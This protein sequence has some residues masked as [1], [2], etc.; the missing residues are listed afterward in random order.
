MRRA[1]AVSVFV[2]VLIASTHAVLAKE[3]PEEAKLRALDQKWSD[4]FVKKD[5]NAV[6]SY[7]ADDAVLM[8]P[9]PALMVRGK[10]AIRKAFAD[11]FA[12]E[13]AIAFAVHDPTYRVVGTLG[14]G[15]ATFDISSKNK[16]T[17][18]T[19]SMKGRASTVFEKRGGKWVAVVD[20]ASFPVP[21]EEPAAAGAKKSPQ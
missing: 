7:Y 2:L 18:Q 6:L 13:D 3:G 8:D 10:D 20:H 5:L 21:E 19:V 16:K 1:F 9:G 17:G 15:Y 11:F 14:Y 4:A 12:D